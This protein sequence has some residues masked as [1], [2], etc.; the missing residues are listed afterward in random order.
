MGQKHPQTPLF[1][2][3]VK[4]VDSVAK[5]YPI[6]MVYCLLE[7]YGQVVSPL[8]APLREG[9]K[10]PKNAPFCQKMSKKFD[11]KLSNDDG[12][13][14]VRSVWTSSFIFFAPLRGIKKPTQN[15]PFCKKMPQ[16]FIAGPKIVQ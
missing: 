4:K 6:M 10:H 7:A 15:A 11:Q 12:L 14:L 5:N 3:N 16:K 8:L 13:W 9:Q 2:N 1:V